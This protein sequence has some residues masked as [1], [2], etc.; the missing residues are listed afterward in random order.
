MYR[1]YKEAKICYT[2]LEDDTIVKITG[3]SA[4]AFG[5]NLHGFSV[6]EKMSWASKRETTRVEDKA[7]CLLGLFD[8]SMPLIYGEGEKAFRRLQEEIIK[9]SDD[10]TIFAWTGYYPYD[11]A[12]ASS[13]SNFKVSGSFKRS[14]ASGEGLYGRA[15]W[16]SSP[17][18]VTNKGLQISLPI[19]EPFSLIPRVLCGQTINDEPFSW[20]YSLA[21]LSCHHISYEKEYVAILIDNKDGP[22]DVYTRRHN[23]LVSVPADIVSE[24]GIMKRITIRNKAPDDFEDYIRGLSGGRL[25]IIPPFPANLG[26][27]T[28]ITMLCVRSED[29][30]YEDPYLHDDGAI[31]VDFPFNHFEIEDFETP[32]PV[33][34]VFK[35]FQGAT[36]LI[37]LKLAYGRR[38]I[39][40]ISSSD[41]EVDDGWCWYEARRA[42]S[43]AE[44]DFS[45]VEL[46]ASDLG[47]AGLSVRVDIR[48]THHAW[49]V[50]INA[51]EKLISQ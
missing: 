16:L 35:N 1:W 49:I 7:Y 27:I 4:Q 28:F 39:A 40:A 34:F 15:D 45:I 8:V 44:Y 29:Y 10:E 14:I 6:A 25:I 17:F 51:E 31:S 13:P 43:D 2:Y 9:E 48:D 33:I 11:V 5:C 20:D 23:W 26:P 30:S 32:S 12:L 46:P 41:E 19:M 38:V 22:G 36:I 47:I 42:L 24:K 50:T 18:T 3:I 21:I 37:S